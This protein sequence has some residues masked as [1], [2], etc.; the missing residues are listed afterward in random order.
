MGFTK[1]ASMSVDALWK[2]HQ[3][4]SD[5]LAAK[6]N[7]RKQEIER[8]LDALAAITKQPKKRRLSAVAKR[9]KSRRPYP[10]VLPKFAN[11]DAPNEV[12]SGRGKKPK[13]VAD[14][15]SEGLALQ[16]LSI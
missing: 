12:W 14:K 2:L 15:L 11:P 9:P 3:Q 8:R 16:D 1:L 10:R 13:W 4:I 5:E 7:Q 6:L